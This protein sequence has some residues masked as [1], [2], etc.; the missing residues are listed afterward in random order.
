MTLTEN[1]IY[2]IA[3]GFAIGAVLFGYI[4]YRV[5]TTE[6]WFLE[7]KEDGEDLESIL[8]QIEL[9]SSTVSDRGKGASK[10]RAGAAD[11]RGLVDEPV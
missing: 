10:R 9:R 3:I 4:V 7:D 8:P 1:G 5:V 2:A 6:W 11:A